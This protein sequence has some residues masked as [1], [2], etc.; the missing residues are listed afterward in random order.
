MS[1]HAIMGLGYIFTNAAQMRLNH[2][3]SVFALQGYN[4]REEPGQQK[5]SRYTAGSV[6]EPLLC[7]NHSKHLIPTLPHLIF[8][9]LMSVATRISLIGISIDELS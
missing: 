5:A 2:W 3:V 6:Y 1:I 7:A 9:A 4:P 8:I